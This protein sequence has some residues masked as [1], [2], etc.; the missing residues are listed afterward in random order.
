MHTSLNK[1]KGCEKQ[2]EGHYLFFFL[3][4]FFFF[5][6]MVSNIFPHNNVSSMN[7][8]ALD[9]VPLTL[10]TNMDIDMLNETHVIDGQVLK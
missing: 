6:F 2:M 7:Y 8:L 5:N 10:G 1:E 9:D 4:F 3:F